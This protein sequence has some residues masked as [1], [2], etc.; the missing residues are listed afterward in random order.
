M[1]FREWALTHG[2][3]E[4]LELERNDNDGNYT[5]ENCMWE[6]RSRNKQNRRLHFINNTSGYRCVF[7]MPQQ[8]TNSWM[9]KITHEKVVYF[10]G[11]YHT[12]ELAAQ[13]VN[14]F[15]IEHKTKHPLNIIP[16]NPAIPYPKNT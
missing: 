2:Y 11:L 4:G 5:L 14:D 1:V 15:I 3:E 9:A 6:T 8:R 7:F 10:L 16:D 12:P 13:V